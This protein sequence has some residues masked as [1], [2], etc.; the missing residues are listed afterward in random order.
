MTSSYT[1]VKTILILAANPQG[2]GILR[3][4]EEIRQVREAL[5]LSSHRDRFVLCPQLAV[6]IE[7]IYQGILS[8]RPQIIHFCS[9]GTVDG[10][11]LLE[12]RNGNIQLVNAEALANLLR[13][14]NSYVEC[15]ILNAC[16]SHIAA[17]EISKHIDF[18]I[19]MNDAISD[20]AAIRFIQAFYCGLGAGKSYKLAY[21][22]GCAD[23]QIRNMPAEIPI[24]KEREMFIRDEQLQTMIDRIC[25]T[26]NPQNQAQ[27]RKAVNRLLIKLQK[28]PG[29]L[30]SSHSMYLEALDQ[31]WE[32]LSQ[33]ICNFIPSLR[34]TIQASLMKEINNYLAMRIGHTISAT[35]WQIPTLSGLDTFIQ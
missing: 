25:T 15:V 16:H 10:Q 29:L 33:N 20:E 9:H 19:G 6:R 22:L 12:D 27:R 23:L 7:D 2:T 30:K 8:Y 32:W 13:I 35:D 3:L 28:L 11:L 26:V 34:G 1:P 14:F 18:A 4:D 5:Q 24:L 17:T 21:E 31:T